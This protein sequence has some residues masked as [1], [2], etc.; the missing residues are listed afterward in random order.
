MD[1][2]QP[3]QSRAEASGL[4]V[5]IILCAS[6]PYADQVMVK[7]ACGASGEGEL[8]DKVVELQMLTCESILV[9]SYQEKRKEKM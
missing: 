1:F 8:S 4:C 2:F 6:L 5:P 7:V 9:Y 3:Q